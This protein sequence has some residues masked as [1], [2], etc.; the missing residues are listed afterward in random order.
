MNTNVWG[1]SSPSYEMA[2]CPLIRDA[3]YTER[4]EYI[5]VNCFFLKSS[6]TFLRFHPSAYMKC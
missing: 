6:L 4:Q 1:G 5:L 3:E 2:Q